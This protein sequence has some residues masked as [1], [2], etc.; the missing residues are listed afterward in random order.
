VQQQ[1]VRRVPAGEDRQQ[2]KQIRIEIAKANSMPRVYDDFTVQGT[3][4]PVFIPFVPK[5]LV[6]RNPSS[7][8]PSQAK[9][10][11]ELALEEH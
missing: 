2:L 10:Y 7:V 5:E 8:I 6:L 1:F 11:S 4:P 9:S 3:W